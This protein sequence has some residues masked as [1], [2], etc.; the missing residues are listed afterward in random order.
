ML[1]RPEIGTKEHIL[2]WL[3]GKDVKAEYEWRCP[4]SCPAGTYSEEFYNYHYRWI[5]GDD[6]GRT[7]QEI[8][9]M[10]KRRPNNYGT[11][12]KRAYK[13]WK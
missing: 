2:L 6:V 12:Y 3:A 10:A 5:E 7:L 8:S 1:S 13:A 11:L 4:H 9:R